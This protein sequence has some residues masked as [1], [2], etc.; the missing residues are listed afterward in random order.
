MPASRSTAPKEPRGAKADPRASLTRTPTHTG[1]GAACADR[2]GRSGLGGSGAG[3]GFGA[4]G[5]RHPEA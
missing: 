3:A 4:D 5:C 2:G 1:S